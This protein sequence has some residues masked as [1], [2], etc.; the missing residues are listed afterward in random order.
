MVTDS[1]GK[2]F[3]Y[4]ICWSVVGLNVAFWMV[5][6]RHTWLNTRA[7]MNNRHD[8]EWLARNRRRNKWY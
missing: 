4:G 3:V 2:G 1:F 7:F 5:L 6:V 8:P